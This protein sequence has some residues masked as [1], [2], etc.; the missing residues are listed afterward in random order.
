MKAEMPMEAKGVAQRN[1]LDKLLEGEELQKIKYDKNEDTMAPKHDNFGPV[2][3][4]G[5]DYMK[6]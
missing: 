2:T 1:C 6:I 5:K 4:G 3:N